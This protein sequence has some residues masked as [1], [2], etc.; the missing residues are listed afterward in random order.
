M[1]ARSLS[2]K[3]WIPDLVESTSPTAEPVHYENCS[4]RVTRSPAT[5]IANIWQVCQHVRGE[6]GPRQTGGAKVSLAQGL[7]A[8]GDIH[9]LEKSAAWQPP[10][11]RGLP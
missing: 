10:R 7:G 6:G 1:G 8:A 11:R 4:R 3:V 5:G 9:V 2:A